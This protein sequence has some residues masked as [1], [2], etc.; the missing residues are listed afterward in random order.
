MKMKVTSFHL[1][2]HD[3]YA[4]N[5]LALRET[6]QSGSYVS[7]SAIVRR[8]IRQFLRSQKSKTE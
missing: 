4:L 7:A 3:L 1:D 2:V 6:E 5:R 8:L